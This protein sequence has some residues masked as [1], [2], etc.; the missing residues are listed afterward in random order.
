[1]HSTAVSDGR[2]AA[3]RNWPRVARHPALKSTSAIEKRMRR[4]PTPMCRSE[5][6]VVSLRHRGPALLRQDI[7]P[8]TPTHSYSD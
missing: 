8:A 7:G 2:N 3:V 1:M 4:Q 6:C 5:L